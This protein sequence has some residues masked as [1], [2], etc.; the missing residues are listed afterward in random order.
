[1]ATAEEITTRLKVWRDENE[2]SNHSW[3]SNGGLWDDV[4]ERIDNRWHQ[5]NDNKN[6]PV[7]FGGGIVIK[8]V[9]DFGGEGQGDDYWIVMEITVDDE[10]PRLYRVEGWYASYD[11]GYLDG[12]LHE[13]RPKEVTRIIYE[14]VK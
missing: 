1:M 8:L 5:G 3:W 6:Q 11:G 4:H 10:P 9:D 2:A 7:D 13:V 14:R 12:D